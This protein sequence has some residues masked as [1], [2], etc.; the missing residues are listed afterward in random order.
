MDHHSHTH[1]IN[2]TTTTARTNLD[3]QLDTGFMENFKFHIF[4][5]QVPKEGLL[6]IVAFRREFPAAFVQVFQLT[7]GAAFGRSQNLRYDRTHCSH[8][9]WRLS[10]LRGELVFLSLLLLLLLLLAVVYHR[11]EGKVKQKR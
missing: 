5:F 11:Y 9:S 7:N 1:M 8:V 4:L 10:S 3:D 2:Y 6:E